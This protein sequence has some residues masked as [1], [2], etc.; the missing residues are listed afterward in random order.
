MDD[1]VPDRGDDLRAAVRRRYADAARSVDGEA[2]DGGCCSAPDA[3][4]GFG[5]PLYALADQQ[6]LPAAAKLASLG[7][8]N[9]AAVAE[10]RP[11]EVVLDLGSGGGIDVLLSAARVG[12]TGRA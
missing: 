5:L 7:C 2:T 9:P 3:G 10:L 4:E 1:A 11:G 12:P 6:G 8:G